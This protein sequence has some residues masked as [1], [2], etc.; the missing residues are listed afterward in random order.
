MLRRPDKMSKTVAIMQP[1]FLPWTGYFGLIGEVDDFVFL[2][3]VQFSKRS[4]QRRNR[5]SGP[6]G[7]V[8]LSLPIASKPSRPKIIETKIASEFN[9]KDILKRAAGC[10]SVA[11]HW[12][13]AEHLLQNALQQTPQGLA[14]VNITFITALSKLLKFTPRFYRS[15]EMDINEQDKAARLYAIC[16]RLEATCYVSAVGSLDYLMTANPFSDHTVAL[17]FQNFSPVIYKQ[18]KGSYISHMSSLDALAWMGKTDLA[19][20]IRI[21][22]KPVYSIEEIIKKNGESN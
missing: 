14:E 3:D 11:P 13:E 5:V 15:S 16:D 1:T 9:S 21:N 7:E 4:W 10:L 19:K 20:A 18:R 8:Q 22:T 17:R 6:N 2:D 12:L